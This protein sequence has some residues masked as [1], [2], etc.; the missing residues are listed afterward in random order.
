MFVSH[1]E[2][3]LSFKDIPFGELNL[4]LSVFYHEFL[5]QAIDL[6]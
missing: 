6:L 3:N 2:E 4:I 1:A 5:K